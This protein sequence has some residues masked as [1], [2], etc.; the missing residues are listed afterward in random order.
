MADRKVIQLQDASGNL[1]DIKDVKS[2]EDIQEL[3]SAVTQ[4]IS[5]TDASYIKHADG[6]VGSN[7]SSTKAS[8]FIAVIPG[9]T[10]NLSGYVG[11]EPI[12]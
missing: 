9:N 8:G 10:F 6:T 4:N 12:W 3:K 11:S 2:Q 7:Y 5:F 1:Y